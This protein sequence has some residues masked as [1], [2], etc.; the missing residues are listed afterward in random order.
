MKRFRYKSGIR[1]S[2][3]QQG[4]I[5]FTSQRY[6]DLPEKRRQKI[7]EMCHKHGGEYAAALLEYVTTDSGEISICRRY[8]LDNSTLERATRRYYE[9]FPKVL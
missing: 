4:Y 8:N 3:L 5:F 2:Y 9:G 7:Q 6:K 1:V